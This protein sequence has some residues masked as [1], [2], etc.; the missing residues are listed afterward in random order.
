MAVEVTPGASSNQP[1]NGAVA[2]TWVYMAEDAPAANRDLLGGK[3]AGL[4]AMTQA[5]LPVPPA[6]TITTAA[7]NAY[8][9][10]NGQFPAGLWDQAL[11]ALKK[12]EA[13]SGRKL[14]D[15]ANPLLV[16]VRSGARESMPGMMDTVLNLGLNDE[17]VEGVIR[18]TEDP[19]FAYDSYRRFVQM[20]AGV[21]LALKPKDKTEHN[22]FEIILERKKK[23]RGVCFDTELT[24]DDLREVVANY[25]AEIKTR[26]GKE[27]PED[28][29]E[30][31]WGAIG[32][33]FGSWN[34]D[35]AIAYRE[36]YHIP[37]QWGTAVNIQ[38][39][40][41]GNLGKNCA[42][43]VAFTRNPS[44]GER[45]FYGEFLVNAQGEDVVAGIR[46][47]KPIS[48]LKTIMPKSYASLQKVAK[49]LEKHYQDMQDIEFT[50]ENDKLWMLQTRTGKR[51][52]F[53]A[54]RIVVDMV[55]ERIISKRDALLRIEADHL[56][57]LLRPI[58]DSQDKDR[59]ANEGRILAK[60]LPAGPGAATGRIVFHAEDAVGWRKNGE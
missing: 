46:T 17:T 35:R 48:E 8:Q 36:L 23:N 31:L 15:A 41:F 38:A 42:T 59:A 21:V 55:S 58:F 39:M 33:V 45:N 53:A 5:G 29:Y 47:P 28:V 19:R 44:T 7:C 22:P 6:F 10:A 26:S 43:G 2:E 57:Q 20:Y 18:R 30:Q 14:G 3:G 50:I 13:S 37:Q 27:F 49:L 12:I 4:A 32:A 16:S 51:T 1:R 24:A 56:N 11:G 9:Q 40:V 54:V 52:G 25:K 60:G 34:N